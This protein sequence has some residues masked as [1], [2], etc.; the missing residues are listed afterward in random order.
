[1]R[2]SPESRDI[3]RDSWCGVLDPLLSPQKK[4][5][6]DITHSAVMIIACKPYA[7]IEDFPPRVK[8]SHE[9]E[10]EVKKKWLDQ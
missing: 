3:V 2:S 8:I 1:M 10:R 6:G 4:E 7:W 9:L 5:L